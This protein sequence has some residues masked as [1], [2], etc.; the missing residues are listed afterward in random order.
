MEPM[1]GASPVLILKR[2]KVL[3]AIAAAGLGLLI[4]LASAGAVAAF[5]AKPPEPI[6][7]AIAGVI[8][9]G[10]MT[11]LFWIF[12]FE[13]DRDVS[14]YDD[15]IVQRIRARRTEIPWASVE[16]LKIKA[17]RIRAGGLIGMALGAAVE[18]ATKGKDKPINQRNT[19]IV[20]TI[21]G[22]GKKIKLT[23]NDQGVVAALDRIQAFINP[24]LTEAAIRQIQQGQTA[25]F[26]PLSLSLQGVSFGKRRAVA[27]PEIGKLTMEKGKIYLKKNGSWLAS[28]SASVAKVPNP[29][30]ALAVYR[31]FAGAAAPAA[32]PTAKDLVGSM[33]V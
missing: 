29:F 16:E 8:A 21:T 11:L 17:I 2:T 27:F 3:R 20:A 18:A 31:H 30:V 15:R 1:P 19:T 26:G 5:A 25:A 7:G 6:L 13:G 14:L 32:Q 12:A 4:L 24:R 9:L 33:Y 23:S 22:G 10:L 28:G